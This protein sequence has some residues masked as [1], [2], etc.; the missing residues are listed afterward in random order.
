MEQEIAWWLQHKSAARMLLVHVS[1]TVAW[2]GPAFSAGSTALPPSLRGLQVEPRWVDMTWF[3]G[4]ESLGS[5]DPRF[6][7]LVLQV[8]CPIHGLARDEA[9][10]LRDSNARRAKRLTRAAIA[11]LSTLLVLALVSAGIA[12]IQARAAQDQARLATARLLNS[13]SQRIVDRNVGL[14]RLLAVQANGLL[15]DDQSRRSMFRSLTAGPHL[16]GEIAVASPRALATN[17]SGTVVVITTQ[18]SR[19]LRWNRKT[20]RV[21]N[22]DTGCKESSRVEVSDDGQVIV[23]SCDDRT[24]F[25]YVGGQ[26]TALGTVDAVAVSPSGRTLAY[27]SDGD[28]RVAKT[29]ATGVSE[30]RVLKLPERPIVSFIA[31]RNDRMLTVI[32]RMNADGRVYAI[33]P[34][35]QVARQAFQQA[36]PEYQTVLSRSGEAYWDSSGLWTIPSSGLPR[37]PLTIDPS[38]DY[39]DFVAMAVSAKGDTAAYASS[40]GSIEVT[41]PGLGANDVTIRARLEGRRDDRPDSPGR[42]RH[43]DSGAR[44]R[45]QRLGSEEDIGHRVAGSAT[46]RGQDACPSPS[47]RRHTVGSQSGWEPG[48]VWRR[49]GNHRDEQSRKDRL[50]N[51]G[52]VQ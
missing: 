33:D 5:E 15:D 43:R 24:G 16:V 19:L 8:F 14:A 28:V 36:A 29:S 22:L 32:D 20:G 3:S 7:E 9:V 48:D 30:P 1:G 27:I 26:R 46:R 38:T 10:A 39:H 25:V 21:D 34:W 45:G 2:E 18:D 44:R 4:P 51:E 50:R 11:S 6:A 40:E 41:K 12:V 49:R 31:L 42:L 13:E 35:R 47:R 23:G 37:G 52:D 17:K